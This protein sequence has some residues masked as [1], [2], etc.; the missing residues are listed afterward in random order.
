MT[1]HRK[2]SHGVDFFSFTSSCRA[3]MNY[4]L[5]EEFSLNQCHHDS[6]LCRW[7]ASPS[8]FPEAWRKA[9]TSILPFSQHIIKHQ[10][11]EHR[12][13]HCTLPSKP[14]QR[15]STRFFK[16]MV[17]TTA[18]CLS[19]WGQSPL[20]CLYTGV[21]SKA[22]NHPCL[23]AAA[24]PSAVKSAAHHQLQWTS[25]TPTSASSEPGGSWVEVNPGETRAQF[26]RTTALPLGNVHRAAKNQTCKIN[27][28]STDRSPIWLRSTLTPFLP[29]LTQEQTVFS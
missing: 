23:G 18:L 16:P 13:S 24:L 27:P 15:R 19:R 28:K 9:E 6:D 12:C 29:A 3:K 4:L 26:R 1:V 2:E 17:L 21:T 14:Q 5:T 10:V 11:S 22:L 7:K 20:P 8:R 25:L